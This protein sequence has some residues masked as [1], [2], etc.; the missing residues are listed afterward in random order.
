MAYQ[1]YH[2]IPNLLK[3]QTQTY[4]RIL[5]S[6]IEEAEAIDWYGQRISVEPDKEAKA[7]MKAAQDEEYKHFSMELEWLSRNSPNWK[8]YLEN[9]INQSGDIVQ[10]GNEAEKKAEQIPG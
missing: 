5:Q 7:I 2:E 1:Q 8:V 10:N 3:P 6:M 4:V 9:I